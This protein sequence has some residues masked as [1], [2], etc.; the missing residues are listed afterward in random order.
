[1]LV[2]MIAERKR[3]FAAQ[4]AAEQRSKPPTKYQMRNRMCTYLRT[5]WLQPQ[6]AKGK[7]ALMNPKTLDKAILNS[8]KK[9]AGSKLKQKSKELKCMKEQESAVDEHE[10]EELRLCLN[11]VQDEDKAINY[12]TLAV[13]S[14]IV[15]SIMLGEFDRQDL[16]DLHRLVMKRFESIAPE[17]YDL[18]LWGDLK[19]MIEPNKED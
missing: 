18:I 17:G 15:F 19:T 3:F 14:P 1:M 6:S 2:E 13:K 9:R 16:F 4:R 7:E 10:K 11:I 12:E 8:K 5:K